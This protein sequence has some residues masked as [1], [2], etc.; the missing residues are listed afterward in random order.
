MSVPNVV[1]ATEALFAVV[2]VSPGVGGLCVHLVSVFGRILIRVFCG[3]R[4]RIV[5]LCG[6]L[7]RMFHRGVRCLCSSCMLKWWWVLAMCFHD[8]DT[9]EP[10]LHCF[11]WL[12]RLGV[13]LAPRGGCLYTWATAVVVGVLARVVV[14]GVLSSAVTVLGCQSLRHHGRGGHLCA[15]LACRVHVLL[16]LRVDLLRW[17]GCTVPELVLVCGL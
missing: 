15:L 4:A 12:L 11:V 3:C 9:P 10:R 14:S 1:L 8:P 16:D 5:C 17:A 2:A 7:Q 6:H 13:R